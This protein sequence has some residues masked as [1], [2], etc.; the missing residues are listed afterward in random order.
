MFGQNRYSISGSG[1]KDRYR[2]AMA[3]MDSLRSGSLY[4][5][6]FAQQMNQGMGDDDQALASGMN[7]SN[8]GFGLADS[9]NKANTQ[10]LFGQTQTGLQAAGNQ[11]RHDVQVDLLENQLANVKSQNS[12]N[13]A[14]GAGKLFLQ[15]LPLAVAAFCERRL[16]QFIRTLSVHRAWEVIRDLPTYT[17]N[18]KHKPN[19]QA[20]GPMVDELETIAPELIVDMGIA[21]DGKPA[22]GVDLAKLAAYQHLALQDALKRIEALEAKL[23]QPQTAPRSELWCAPL[24]VAA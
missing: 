22:N 5:R 15:A 20:Y 12:T 4:N 1:N 18:Y 21:P 23:D 24:E 13:T 8:F 2:N 6:G 3:T 9:F 19:E 10:A 7:T 16:K 14:V 17:F 11:K